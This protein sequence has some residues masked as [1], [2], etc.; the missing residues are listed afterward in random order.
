MLNLPLGDKVAIRAAGLVDKRD[1]FFDERVSD[2]TIDR[3]NSSAGRVKPLLKPT[4]TLSLPFS[5]EFFM[6]G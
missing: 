6:P 3:R 4:E 2:R 1:G 5:G